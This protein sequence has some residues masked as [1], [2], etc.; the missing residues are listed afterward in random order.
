MNGWTRWSLEVPSSLGCSMVLCSM[1]IISLH[2]R[3]S[4]NISIFTAVIQVYILPSSLWWEVY[5]LALVLWFLKEKFSGEDAK[6]WYCFLLRVLYWNHPTL[7][8]IHRHLKQIMC[9]KH[10]CS[11]CELH[12]AR[13]LQAWMPPFSLPGLSRNA[14]ATI[15]YKGV[16]LIRCSILSAHTGTFLKI[17]LWGTQT[18]MFL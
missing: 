12:L 5:R 18:L 2:A 7:W 10:N 15:P 16:M 17:Y 9:C 4:T 1:T 8:N 6:G 11:G 3:K 14:S 13:A